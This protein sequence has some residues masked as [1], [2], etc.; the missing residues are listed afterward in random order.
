M[1]LSI[2]ILTELCYTEGV[3]T[4]GFT[5]RFAFP[6]AVNQHN[7]SIVGKA[8]RISGLTSRRTSEQLTAANVGRFVFPAPERDNP[9][10]RSQRS[11]MKFV[12]R[13]VRSGQLIR[14]NRCE[15]CD[16]EPVEGYKKHATVAHHWNGYDDPL[17]IWWVCHSCNRFLAY[18]HDGSLTKEEARIYVR[19]R[20]RAKLWK[21]RIVDIEKSQDNQ[22]FE[23]KMNATEEKRAW[24]I[25][26]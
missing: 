19:K 5:G 8:P 26:R 20:Q 10:M 1:K 13:A 11:A 21:Y 22:G 16:T 25:I 3:Q 17:N 9:D 23:F 2:A 6:N 12:E 15:T 7:L 14:P 18:K 4:F 24:R